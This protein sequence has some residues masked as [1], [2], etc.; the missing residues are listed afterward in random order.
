MQASINYLWAIVAKV[1]AGLI[2]QADHSIRWNSLEF[3][4]QTGNFLHIL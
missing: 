2:P 1:K 3:W 4:K